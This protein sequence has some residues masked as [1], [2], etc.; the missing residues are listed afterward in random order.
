MAAPAVKGMQGE[1]HYNRL[2]APQRLPAGPW[3]PGVRW[4]SRPRLSRA[5]W[6]PRRVFHQEHCRLGG[7]LRARLGLPPVSEPLYPCVEDLPGWVQR[8]QR[9]SSWSRSLAPSPPL[10]KASPALAAVTPRPSLAAAPAWARS[11][12]WL[13]AMRRLGILQ[14]S[15]G[16]LG[17]KSGLPRLSTAPSP[18]IKPR[19]QEKK[20]QVSAVS[21]VP[22]VTETGL[23]RP[24]LSG[25]RS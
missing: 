4:A 8:C 20:C 9:E 12:L 17:R 3:G 11:M 10:P 23:L 19:R 15:P 14:Q 1:Q 21:V 24:R 13:F 5:P 6:L 7:K 22:S 2:P 18:R 16:G 25:L